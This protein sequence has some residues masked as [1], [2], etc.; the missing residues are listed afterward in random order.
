MDEETGRI[1]LPETSWNQ[2]LRA[3]AAISL[4]AQVAGKLQRTQHILDVWKTPTSGS[5]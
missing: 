3:A 2:W 5:L 1:V 4:V